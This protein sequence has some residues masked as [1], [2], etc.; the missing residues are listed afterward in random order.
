[1]AKTSNNSH[2]ESLQHKADLINSTPAVPN[3]RNSLLRRI[4]IWV[5]LIAGVMLIGAAMIYF[6]LYQPA[7][8]ERSVLQKE[9][10]S[11][12]REMSSVQSDL[13][14]TRSELII[15]QETV[16]SL[17]AQLSEKD[18]LL[19]R[20]SQNELVLK[21]LAEAN[22]A[23]NAYGIQ[24]LTTIRIALANIGEYLSQID[25][26]VLDPAMVSGILDRTIQAQTSMA[27]Q[28]ESLGAEL[29]ALVLNLNQL[30]NLISSQP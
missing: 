9:L 11:V 14:A 17:E 10:E 2:Q 22:I 30:L 6:W 3:S 25:S 16:D 13:Q 8:R 18:Q 12:N 29:D 24:D 27:S 20:K 15:A 7:V 21:A 28:S 19:S 4:M 5:A 26:S 1:M 23:Q